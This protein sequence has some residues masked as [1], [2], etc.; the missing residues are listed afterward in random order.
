MLP[1][2]T[3]NEKNN[4]K[5]P[6]HNPQRAWAEPGPQGQFLEHTEGIQPQSQPTITCN[7]FINFLSDLTQSNQFIQINKVC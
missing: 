3:K 7:L 5:Q 4:N 1:T 2:V 6:K